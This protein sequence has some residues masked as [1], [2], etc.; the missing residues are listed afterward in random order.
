M[1]KMLEQNK[2]NKELKD[3]SSDLE[4]QLAVMKKKL[5][6]ANI[7]SNE[8][9]DHPC[10]TTTTPTTNDT[11]QSKDKVDD[12]K[13]SSIFE[14]LDKVNEKRKKGVHRK[15]KNKSATVK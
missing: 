14:I 4:R 2:R 12:K 5:E 3:R 15:K 11:I 13:K 1:K 6:L 10:N 8:D 7:D 9:H